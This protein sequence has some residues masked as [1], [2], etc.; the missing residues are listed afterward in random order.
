MRWAFLMFLVANMALAG[1]QWARP[2]GESAVE[3]PAY[4]QEGARLKLLSEVP[5]QELS[6]DSAFSGGADGGNSDGNADAEASGDEA[7]AGEPRIVEEEP[8][9]AL[10]TLVGPFSALL[11]AEYFLEYLA[12]EGIVSQITEIEVPGPPAFWVY[13]SPLGS[14][15]L[16]YQKLGE[17]QR[18]GIDSY[19]IPKGELEN[20]I[21]FGL[22]SQELGG[23]QRLAEV[24]A[25]GY[26][27]ALK[28]VERSNA[29]IWVSIE[30][31]EAKKITQQQWLTLLVRDEGLEM[32][33]NFCPAV[34]SE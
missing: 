33:Q 30:A 27:A 28:R 4:R 1:Y 9:S 5:A 6:R 3:K 7:S 23:L 10:C 17:L 13:L 20:G 25:L 14:R 31:V 22:F 34:A 8:V 15:S 32:R 26:P 21:S 29:E 18:E 11:R 12:E 2:A 19:V 16:A 24:K